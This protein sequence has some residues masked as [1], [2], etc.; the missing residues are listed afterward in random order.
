MPS[1]LVLFAVEAGA[2]RQKTSLLAENKHCSTNYT[3]PHAV[4]QKQLSRKVE[5]R[6]STAAG[7][8]HST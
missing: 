4:D 6:V 5:T 2:S 1:S 3:T 8:L 7:A